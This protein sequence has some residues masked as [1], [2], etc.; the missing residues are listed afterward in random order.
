M[1]N[2]TDLQILIISRPRQTVITSVG[3]DAYVIFRTPIWWPAL[4]NVYKTIKQILIIKYDV[5][6]AF[7]FDCILL[8]DK[9][10]YALIVIVCFITAKTFHRARIDGRIVKT[11]L[12]NSAIRFCTTFFLAPKRTQRISANPFGTH[13][14]TIVRFQYAFV[15]VCRLKIQNHCDTIAL[16]I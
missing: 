12:L 10:T 6:N 4:I 3:V 5:F 16:L 8:H 14:T 11:T 7:E 15:V 1:F 13:N 2:W 9:L